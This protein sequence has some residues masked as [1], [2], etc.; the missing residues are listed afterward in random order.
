MLSQNETLIMPIV[1]LDTLHD[2]DSVLSQRRVT[3]AKHN[4]N[5]NN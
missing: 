2:G 4:N 3:Y 1:A 5:A